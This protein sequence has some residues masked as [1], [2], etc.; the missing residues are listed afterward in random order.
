[1]TAPRYVIA[2]VDE[3]APMLLV[4]ADLP[5]AEHIHLTRHPDGTVTAVPMEYHGC[6][7][8]HWTEHRVCCAGALW[9]DA[10]EEPS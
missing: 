2:K 4:V 3:Q 7:C 1:M 10:P 8:G 5:D 9:V 6:D